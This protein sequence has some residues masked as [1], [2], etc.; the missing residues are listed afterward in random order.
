[1]KKSW[2]KLLA[3]AIMLVMS[4]GLIAGCT[5]Q[6]S[7]TGSTSGGGTTTT[8]GETSGSGLSGDVDMFV[9]WSTNPEQ[10]EN[11]VAEYENENPDVKV[12]L[13]FMTGDG[14]ESNLEVRIASQ[15]MPELT[16]A[17][18]GSWYYDAADNGYLGDVSSTEA[19]EKLLPGLQISLTSPK[20]VKFGVPYGVAY[21]YCYYNKAQ[22]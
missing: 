19:W 15:T 17:G 20:G 14:V 9:W 10:I 22:F 21:M 5:T 2:L 16:S 12:N 13:T 18:V 8:G 6:D 7:T 11:L 4:I 3:L 1:M